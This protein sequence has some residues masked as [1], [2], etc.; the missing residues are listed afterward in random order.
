MVYNDIYI[1]LNKSSSNKKE[2]INKIIDKIFNLF[3]YNN[4]NLNFIFKI[5]NILDQKKCN[6]Q[7]EQNKKNY[8][9]RYNI[10]EDQIH[11]ICTYRLNNDN[12]SFDKIFNI[13][14]FLYP[15]YFTYALFFNQKYEITNIKG[16]CDLEFIKN[17]SFYSRDEIQR[18]I[19]NK[20][21]NYQKQ[22]KNN[23][24]DLIL[25]KLL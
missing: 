7:F 8:C 20:I 25:T 24:T 19:I 1:G 2:K 4:V 3:N 21:Y 6:S 11:Y 10:N 13:G 22:I 17:C 18:K 5:F 12:N 9:F 15:H 14:F 16:S 23:L